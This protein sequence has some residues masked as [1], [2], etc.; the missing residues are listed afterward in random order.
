MDNNPESTD[1]A[2]NT[3]AVEPDTADTSHIEGQG[4][5]DAEE[6]PAA[7]TPPPAAPQSNLKKRNRTLAWIAIAA[8]ALAAAGAI[9]AGGLVVGK[10]FSEQRHDDRG[11]NSGQLQSGGSEKADA[12]G[13]DEESEKTSKKKSADTE[14]ETPAPAKSDSGDS[15][16]QTPAPMP[17]PSAATPAPVKPANTAANTPAPEPS[18]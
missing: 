13:E 5:R 2:E 18:R 1:P 3:E 17:T 7:M 15:E 11:Y 8:G 12:E 10:E 4:P 9:F 14:S 16:S 6:H